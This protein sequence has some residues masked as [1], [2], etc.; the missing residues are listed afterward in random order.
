MTR[1]RDPKKSTQRPEV[2]VVAMQQRHI[3]SDPVGWMARG[4]AMGSAARDI[5]P[6]RALP[7][8]A[9]AGAWAALGLKVVV[10]SL[11]IPLAA[12]WL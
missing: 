10:A 12:R 2:V 1:S 4:L 3:R 9:D 6:A 5:G 11:L 8:N 7:V